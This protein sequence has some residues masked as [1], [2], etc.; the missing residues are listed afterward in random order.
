[1]ASMNSRERIARTLRRQPID[2]VGVLESFWADTKDAWVAGGHL[3]AEEDIEAHFGF[4]IR[5]AGWP[6][7]TADL[8]FG[9]QIVEET[10]ETR[11]VRDG[12][13]ALLRRMKTHSTTPEHVDF[14]VKEIGRA[15]CR[16][17]V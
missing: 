13:G 6:R 7:F 3:K 17:R 15:S 10:A 12:N 4:D 1:M 2:H 16:E 9:E 14:A 5:R 11:L 8:D